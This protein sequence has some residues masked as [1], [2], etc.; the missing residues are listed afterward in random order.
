[1]SLKET[2]KEIS[3]NGFKP[4]FVFEDVGD[5]V[6]G[7]LG[8]GRVVETMYGIRKVYDLGDYTIWPNTYLENILNGIPPG[9]YVGIEY[10]GTEFTKDKKFRYKKFR[11]YVDDNEDSDRVPQDI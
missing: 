8:P 11:V 9:S 10:V 6:E 1:M 5:Y 3:G 2:G 7:T 4:T